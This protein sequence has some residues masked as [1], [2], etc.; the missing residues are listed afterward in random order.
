MNELNLQTMCFFVVKFDCTIDSYVQYS[1]R[2]SL[3]CATQFCTSCRE[4]DPEG[5][6]KV[7][8][9]LEF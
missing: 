9:E 2:M 7:H 4:S 1:Y 8:A 5:D 6:Y 3:G